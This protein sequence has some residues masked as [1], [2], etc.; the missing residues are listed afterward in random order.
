MGLAAFVVD[1]IAREHAYKPIDGDVL[2]V[3]RQTVYLTPDRLCDRLRRHG[4]TPD[5]SAIEVDTQTIDRL[6]GYENQTLVSDRSIFRA[7]GNERVKA[8]DVSPYE[9]AEVIHDLNLPLSDHLKGIADFVVDGSTLD[10]T[11]NPAQTL[12]NFAE[13]LRPGGRL[14]TINAFSTFET[15]YVIMPP[16]WYYDYFVVN[17]FADVKV[18]V[19]VP[20]NER[21]RASIYAIDADRLAELKREMG[22]LSSIYSMCTV[23]FAEKAADSTS[24]RVPTQQHYRPAEQWTSYL[25]ALSVIRRSKRPHHLAS[26]GSP[27][28]DDYPGG[29]KWIDAQYT[30]QDIP[31]IWL[32]YRR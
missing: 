28:L 32:R 9:G 25:D 19:S 13:L 3:G 20:D 17:R 30:A 12:R 2:L 1:A 29:Y 4:Y 22:H 7:L 6:Q 24:D 18:Y 27:V 16:L 10:N 14:L 21:K 8:I 15:A 26:V 31:P 11:F 23:V 5:P